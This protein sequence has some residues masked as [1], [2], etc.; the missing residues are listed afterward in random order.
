ML[1]YLFLFLLVLGIALFIWVLLP[2]EDAC[3]KIEES[4][5]FIFSSINIQPENAQILDEVVNFKFK[6]EYAIKSK[7]SRLLVKSCGRVLLPL[8]FSLIVCPKGDDPDDFNYLA[9]I[10]SSCL[11]RIIQIP[12]AIYKLTPDFK[13]DFVSKKQG[14]WWVVEAKDKDAD[15]QCLAWY[16]D[17]IILSS[18][19]RMFNNLLEANTEA[20]TA[21][22]NILLRILIDNKRGLFECYVDELKDKASYDIFRSADKLRKIS[23]SLLASDEVLNHE[24]YMV[25]HFEIGSDLTSSKK[26]IRF[27][28]QFI[29][30]V[31]DANSY[32]F[33][34]T[35]EE[36]VNSVKVR[37]SLLKNRREN[38]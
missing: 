32:A 36:N 34:Y 22:D 20:G 35:I 19:G 33:K 3:L 12:L 26:D 28:M 38:Q 6:E 2:L 4:N 31:M 23:I 16:A 10:K 13:S 25:F 29:R 8:N 18:D 37:Y 14:N 11:M 7:W 24:G 1:K 5:Y 9:L 17:T 15:L 27:F 21:S 30:R